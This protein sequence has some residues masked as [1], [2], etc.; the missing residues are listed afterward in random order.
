M[1]HSHPMSMTQME[2]IF[3]ELVLGETFPKPTLVRLLKVKYRAV[4]YLSLMEGPDRG[5]LSLYFLPS[6][7]AKLSSQPVSVYGL[8]KNPMA[9]QRHASQCAMSAKVHM[10]R[11][12][13]AAPYSE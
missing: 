5:S 8:S 6:C 1:L 4:T 10:S 13:T 2:K 12:R 7:C 11:N 3:S 9:Y